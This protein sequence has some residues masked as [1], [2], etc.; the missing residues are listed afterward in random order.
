[1]APPPPFSLFAPT[2]NDNH[3]RPPK[4]SEYT[5]SDDTLCNDVN[6]H[7]VSSIDDKQASSNTLNE[8]GGVLTQYP[9]FNNRSVNVEE[10]DIRETASIYLEHVVKRRKIDSHAVL[11]D[12]MVGS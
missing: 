11:M 9:K 2:H 1:M 5:D 6:P 3:A 4:G 10:P 8:S 12:E 7:S